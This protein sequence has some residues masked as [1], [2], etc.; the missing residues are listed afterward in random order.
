MT[1]Y[2]TS[3]LVQ[4]IECIPWDVDCKERSINSIVK[5]IEVEDTERR[6]HNRKRKKRSNRCGTHY[7]REW[8]SKMD[9]CRSVWK[10]KRKTDWCCHWFL[11]AQD[12]RILQYSVGNS[13]EEPTDVSWL[14]IVALATAFLF[15]LHYSYTKK[16]TRMQLHSFFLWK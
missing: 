10:T 11:G 5:R 9:G 2:L 15:L 8:I 4:V 1:E 3:A 16:K 7:F 13:N 6:I 12:V 14:L